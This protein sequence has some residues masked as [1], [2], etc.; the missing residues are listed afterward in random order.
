MRVGPPV[1]A[2]PGTVTNATTRARGI[3][4][5]TVL[6]AVGVIRELTSARE[7][8]G[9]L[10]RPAWLGDAEPRRG[11][12]F[13]PARSRSYRH[14]VVPPEPRE[15]CRT[16]PGSRA[17]ATLPAM[18][19]ARDP[20]P[21]T[22]EWRHGRVRLVDQR[23]LPHRLVLRRVRVGRRVGDCD[24]IARGAWRARTRRGG[25]VRRARSRRRR[26]PPRGCAARLRRLARARPT[27]VNLSWG[28]ER[29]LA[30]YS[31]GGAAAALAEAQRIADADV[32]G[33]RA[34]GAFGADTDR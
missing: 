14:V 9:R 31:A 22:I 13:D 34:L 12:G 2:R 10:R 15:G 29:A 24:P 28:V 33:N 23:V 17:S 5:S 3:A 8:A 25:R 7:C 27:A 11:A 16:D 32:A 1:S 26:S 4:A 6:R 30:A 20:I 21:P 19:G 18:T